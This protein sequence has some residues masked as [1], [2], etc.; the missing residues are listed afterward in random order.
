[1]SVS[2]ES[3]ERM[4]EAGRTTRRADGKT[5]TERGR[6]DMLVCVANSRRWATGAAIEEC[7]RQLCK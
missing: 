4:R 6:D 3:L 2:E 1:M 7:R 5:A